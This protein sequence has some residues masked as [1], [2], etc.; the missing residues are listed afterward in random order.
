MSEAAAGAW[1][2][3]PAFWSYMHLSAAGIA[4]LQPSQ[5]HGQVFLL[6]SRAV[7]KVHAVGYVVNVDVRG[8]MVA[9]TLDDGSGLVRCVHWLDS[10]AFGHLSAADV[11]RHSLGLGRLVSVRGKVNVYRDVVQINVHAVREE[12]D[13]N[14]EIVHWLRVR[15]VLKRYLA[16]RVPWIDDVVDQVNALAAALPDVGRGRENVP[17]V[18]EAEMD[19]ALAA[20]LRGR[21]DVDVDE[22]C[23]DDAMLA[24]AKR[25]GR[26]ARVLVAAAIER[27]VRDG[28][29][30]RD[31][32]S[33]RVSTVRF[34]DNLGPFLEDVVRSEAAAGQALGTVDLGVILARMH[35]DERFAAISRSTAAQCLQFLADNGRIEE[36]ETAE[37][38]PLAV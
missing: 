27:A 14:A 8:M 17:P 10:A 38:R 33:A 13:P 2:A 35:A 3:H 28:V 34:A 19:R 24:L 26:S 9:Y 22:A 11:R 31:R 23:K 4:A 18:D 15:K 25:A 32:R 29:L 20:W 37:F 30:I 1:G 5:Q 7:A 16:A 36:T 6:G 21:D 12:K